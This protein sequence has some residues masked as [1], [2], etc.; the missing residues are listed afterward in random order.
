MPTAT[1][2]IVELWAEIKAI[3]DSIDENMSAGTLQYFYPLLADREVEGS[4]IENIFTQEK[5]WYICVF[6]SLDIVL[7]VIMKIY[8]FKTQLFIL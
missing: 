6:N 7:W 4:H 3:I 1:T 5:S 8:I 2:L